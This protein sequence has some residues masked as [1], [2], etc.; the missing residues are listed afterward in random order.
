MI[1]Y[2]P[3]PRI[4]AGSDHLRLISRILRPN[5]ATDTQ[6]I[7]LVTTSF[8]RVSIVDTGERPSEQIA[9][10]DTAIHV[11]WQQDEDEAAIWIDEDRHAIAPGDTVMIP[12]GDRFRLSPNT[13]IVLVSMRK[14]S[15]SL[16][17]PPTHGDYHFNGYN[18]E[19]RY[20][21]DAGFALSRWK[22]TDTLTFGQPESERVLI[23]LYADFAIQ[24]S[25]G[26][27]ML[28]QGEASV[29]RP[30]VGRITLVPNGLSYV[31]V[32]D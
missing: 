24:H 25:G 13:L 16:P 18:R 8:K 15:L 10:G 12:G 9:E 14:H 11:L 21:A 3:I 6:R 22:I 19:S 27:T 23:S 31:L 7:D 1:P 29:I 32:I 30:Q 5:V 20:P 26:V 2:S 4:V 17:I 28:R